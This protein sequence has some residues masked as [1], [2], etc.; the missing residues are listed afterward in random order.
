MTIRE[1]FEKMIEGGYEVEGFDNL[2]DTTMIMLL[3]NFI[4][5]PLVWQAV[6]KVEGWNTT[7]KYCKDVDHLG[8]YCEFVQWKQEMHRM[9]DALCEGKSIIDFLDTL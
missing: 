1:F 3:P 5:K 8:C 4:L 6:G 7:E 9:I 2:S